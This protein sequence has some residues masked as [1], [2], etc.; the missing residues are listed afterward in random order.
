MYISFD[1]ICEEV[2]K[3]KTKHY[4]SDPFRLCKAMGI[5]VL[6]APMGEGSEACKGFYL[7]HNR[8]KTITINNSLSSEFARIICSHELGHAVLHKD[9]AGVKA[10]HDFGLFDSVSSYEYEANIFA[11][12]LLLE[13]GD[14]LNSLNDD[15]SFFQAASTL[16]VPA[17]I[18]DFKFRILKWKGYKVTDAPLWSPG[19]WL[20][21]A[22][23]K[24]T[25]DDF[26]GA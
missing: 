3:L 5:K 8:I 9:K 6:Y 10:F 19:N 14:V 23:D 1:S 25:P 7:I 22:S 2:E 11:A 4:E 26:Y 18:L 16:N 13:D 24:G 12:E 15:L 21:D 20:K 17:E